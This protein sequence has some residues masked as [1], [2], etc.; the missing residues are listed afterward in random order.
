MLKNLSQL[1]NVGLLAGG[2]LIGLA[3]GFAAHK[4]SKPVQAY[5]MANK[6]LETAYQFK[7]TTSD[8]SK[9][10]RAYFDAMVMNNKEKVDSL[11]RHIN[12]PN[13]K[14]GDDILMQIEDAVVNGIAGIPPEKLK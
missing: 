8:S 14:L 10:Y 6:Y 3:G 4:A 11:N 13:L 12:H 7:P 2:A 5:D 9:I 1:R